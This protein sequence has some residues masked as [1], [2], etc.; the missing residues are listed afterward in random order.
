MENMESIILF[1]VVIVVMFIVIMIV[2]PWKTEEDIVQ[3]VVRA[4]AKTTTKKKVVKV[5]RIKTVK[6]EVKEP[7]IVDS[8]VSATVDNQAVDSQVNVSDVS[9]PVTLETPVTDVNLM[10][11]PQLRE[12]A[13]SKGITGY[14]SMNKTEL[15]AKL[16]EIK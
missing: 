5:D 11:V 8:T 6:T 4:K 10:T 15:L 13:K 3:P 12:A 16:S 7:L 9:S 2:K 14:S 1:G